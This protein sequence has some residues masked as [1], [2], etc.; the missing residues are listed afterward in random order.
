[1]LRACS[2]QTPRLCLRNVPSAPV[3]RRVALPTVRPI[4]G[5]AQQRFYCPRIPRELMADAKAAY[6]K[7]MRSKQQKVAA[8]LAEK[9]TEG[10]EYAVPDTVADGLRAHAEAR[11]PLRSEDQLPENWLSS[12]SDWALLNSLFAPSPVY[13]ML[14]QFVL[15]LLRHG[16]TGWDGIAPS[17]SLS[18]HTGNGVEMYSDSDFIFHL[19]GE[20]Y[21]FSVG[22]ALKI[23]RLNDGSDTDGMVVGEKPEGVEL[24]DRIVINRDTTARQELFD[25]GYLPF[26]PE[27]TTEQQEQTTLEISEAEPEFSPDEKE[28]LQLKSELDNMMRDLGIEPPN[29]PAAYEEAMTKAMDMVR[30]KLGGMENMEQF[31]E[32]VNKLMKILDRTQEMEA[33]F[34]KHSEK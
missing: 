12:M 4:L 26:V 3:S 24:F 9:Q 16:L 21:L 15:I 14:P 23:I 25:K 18:Q 6:M 33:A 19:Q 29:E 31:G 20:R 1:M 30:E 28:V 34:S 2:R 32:E 5:V 22:E 17:V 10:V 27:E 7:E 13:L 11:W 8:R